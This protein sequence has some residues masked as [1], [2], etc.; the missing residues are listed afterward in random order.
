MLPRGP[1]QNRREQPQQIAI[2]VRVAAVGGAHQLVKFR[3]PQRH[4]LIPYS[5]ATGPP[6]HV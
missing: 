4:V 3:L 2:R 6:L 5:D 1:A